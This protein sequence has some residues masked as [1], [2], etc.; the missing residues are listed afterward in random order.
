MLTV[1]KLTYSSECAGEIVSNSML[2]SP[3]IMGFSSHDITKCCVDTGGVV[4]G[5]ATVAGGGVD[6]LEAWLLILAE[7]E[8]SPPPVNS[9]CCK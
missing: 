5:S 6:I 2:G 1:K 4:G 9:W 7:K 8:G 3:V